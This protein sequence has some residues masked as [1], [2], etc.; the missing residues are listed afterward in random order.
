MG[1]NDT[2]SRYFEF[3]MFHELGAP[4]KRKK[5]DL[6]NAAL[7]EILGKDYMNDYVMVDGGDEDK[8]IDSDIESIDDSD[9]DRETEDRYYSWEINLPA[10]C[11]VDE[12]LKGLLWN[13]ATYQEG[14]CATYGYNYGKRVSPTA[15]EIAV[16]FKNA[17]DA[18]LSVGRKELLSDEFVEPLDA[19]LSCLAALP[20]QLQYLIPEPYRQLSTDNSVED[21]YASCM[22]EEANVFDLQR[23]R[24]LCLEAIENERK[25]TDCTSTS[26]KLRKIRTGDTFWTVLRKTNKP[27]V[28]PFSPPQPFSDRLS[29]LKKSSRIQAM[30]MVAAD[31][32]RW[33]QKKVHKN[34][35]N[36]MDRLMI[37]SLGEKQSLEN[38][39]YRKA[40]QK[41]EIRTGSSQ[42]VNELTSKEDAFLSLQELEEKKMKRDNLP[43]PSRRI[44]KNVEGLNALQCLKQLEDVQ[45]LLINWSQESPSVS[46]Y[47]ATDPDSYEE[48][49]LFVNKF[50][51]A[52]TMDSFSSDISVKQDR[53]IFVYGR[54]VMKR[55]LA[56]Q[57]LDRLFGSSKSWTLMTVNE[58][59]NRLS[60]PAK[61]VGRDIQDGSIILNIE[62]RSAIV[63]LH[64]L[65]DAHLVSV[66]WEY[67]SEESKETIKLSIER[68][69]SSSTG[70]S[71]NLKE[72][73]NVYLTSKSTSKKNL[74]E[75]ALKR[76]IG[77][78]WAYMTLKQM[79][80]FLKEEINAE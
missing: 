53:N 7:E 77:D 60:S 73:R 31:R 15:E 43:I 36:N 27:L 74:S 26:D 66:Q 67:S 42:G 8:D 28:H 20:S 70:L 52:D 10:E 49:R 80:L 30:H 45:V 23:F 72:S 54:Q 78:Q 64:E 24:K 21:I 47:A 46:D 39:G 50:A 22:E 5:Q 34:T 48:V 18:G 14:V 44:K 32:P 29:R 41:G 12:Y 55:H 56:N 1:S 62:N 40:F 79:K 3:D 65:M 76:L 19:G 51:E 2:G 4:L 25:G 38:V 35:S 69:E 57:A 9:D 59:N 6:A 71:F 61:E 16:Y 58:M 63:C 75:L 33:L 11:N 68:L 17:V 37:N 13:L